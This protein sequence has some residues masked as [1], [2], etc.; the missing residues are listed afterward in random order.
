M[1]TMLRIL[2]PI[3][4]LLFNINI[5]YAQT[6]SW[7]EV[8]SGIYG[9]KV[10]VLAIS[11]SGHIFAGTNRGGIYRSTDNGDNW[12]QINNGLTNSWV[13]SLAISD[14]G[15]IFAGAGDVFRST[16]NGD[17]WT[18]INNGLINNYVVIERKLIS[19]LKIIY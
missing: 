5:T 11:D 19:V 9:G 3:S 7:E 17:N 18:Q 14:S 2:V 13:T 6:N 4:L 1:K 10:E 15:Y 16:D 8:N 12:I